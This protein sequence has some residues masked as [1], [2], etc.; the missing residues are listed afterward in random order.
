MTIYDIAKEA[1]VSASTVS[2]VMNNK[3]G[4]KAETRE[5][6]MAVVKKYNFAP[7]ETARGLV[8]QATK[9]IGLLIGDV[10]ITN[11]M[12]GIHSIITAMAEQSYCCIVLDTGL[13]SAT[14]AEYVKILS[15][16]RVEG[17][18][19][20]GAGY[21]CPE[22]EE[23]I[24]LYLKNVPVVIVNGA[25]DMP[26]VYSV[27]S[28]E[29]SATSLCLNYV[30]EKGYKHP[31]YIGCGSMVGNQKR[32]A[33]IADS[34]AKN[35]P[36]LEVPTYISKSPFECGYRETRTALEEHP[37]TDILVYSADCFAVAGMCMLQELGVKVP[38]QLGIIAAEE[39]IYSTVSHPY[40]TSLDVKVEYACEAA[41]RIMLDIFAG[42]K[43][44][45]TVMLEPKM[46]ERETTKNM[47]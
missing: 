22:V 10:R 29:R 39:S 21:Q 26:N 46:N 30:F 35:A 18:I 20:V 8:R 7:D 16:R 45:K 3:P 40:M 5:R 41:C 34:V 27:F 14:R 38:E 15:Q 24:R 32:L 6:V 28:D 19:L 36:G 11:Y 42:E 9:T 43:S 23:A 1:G 4:L 25:I 33:G 2:R 37:E 13:D 44:P 12:M 31:A 47:N 17:A